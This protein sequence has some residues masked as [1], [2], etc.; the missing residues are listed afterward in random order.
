MA[1]KAT[2]FHQHWQHITW[3]SPLV[4]AAQDSDKVMLMDQSKDVDQQTEP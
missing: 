3:R 1:L 2:E 4:Q